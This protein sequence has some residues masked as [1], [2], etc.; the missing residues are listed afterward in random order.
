M[1]LRM[2]CLN[3]KSDSTKN[4]KC[5]CKLKCNYELRVVKLIFDRARN[6]RWEFFFCSFKGWK[7]RN[8]WS[9]NNKKN[10]KVNILEYVNNYN[11]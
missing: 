4:K 8:Y 2:K 1:F 6:S 9:C 3:K 10:S 5:V 11:E 7:L